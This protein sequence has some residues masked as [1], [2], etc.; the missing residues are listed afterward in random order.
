MLVPQG[1]TWF[2]KSTTQLVGQNYCMLL[3]KR[4]SSLNMQFGWGAQVTLHP[5]RASV[6]THVVAAWTWCPTSV[7]EAVDFC[8]PRQPP[9]HLFAAANDDSDLNLTCH[10]GNCP[11]L[12]APNCQTS[13]LFSIS[14]RHACRQ[15]LWAQEG[16]TH[17]SFM[18]CGLQKAQVLLCAKLTAN[19]IRNKFRGPKLSGKKTIFNKESKFENDFLLCSGPGLV[20]YVGCFM[21]W[22]P[23]WS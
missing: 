14:I 7:G 19:T 8:A 5:F 17:Q 2:R 4:L 10:R 6:A 18:L 22:T 21:L 11:I 23:S 1:A 16:A 15:P 12:W 20:H 3:L 13:D 9:S